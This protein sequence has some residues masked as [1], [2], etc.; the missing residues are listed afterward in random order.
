MEVNWTVR[1]ELPEVGVAD[2]VQV[3]VQGGVIVMEPVLVQVAASTMTVSAQVKV[4]AA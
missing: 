1:G 3:M 4:P 2:A